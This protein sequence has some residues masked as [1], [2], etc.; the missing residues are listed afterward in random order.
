MKKKLA[1]TVLALSFLT[2]GISTHHHS[3]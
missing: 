2:A 3:A 1:T